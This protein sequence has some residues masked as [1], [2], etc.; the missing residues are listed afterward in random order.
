MCFV[1]S[2]GLLIITTENSNKEG[3]FIRLPRS[4]AMK[5]K[6]D[7]TAASYRQE[8]FSSIG[9]AGDS[10]GEHPDRKR[11]YPVCWRRVQ[12]EEWG[13]RHLGW[14]SGH[15]PALLQLSRKNK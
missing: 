14:Q 9:K 12:T 4:S 2:P 10:G 3:K 15:S 5:E 7:H 1:H 6:Q 8:E 11:L 13:A